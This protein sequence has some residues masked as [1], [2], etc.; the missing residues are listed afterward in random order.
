MKDV[1]NVEALG[2]SRRYD[3]GER[4][5]KHDGRTAAPA[6]EFDR[7]KPRKW[8]GKCPNNVTVEQRVA[9]LNEAVAGSSGDRSLAGPKTVYAVHDGA[10]YEAQTSDGGASYH[11]YPYRG[12]LPGRIVRVLR[13]RADQKECRDAFDRWVKEHIEVRGSDQ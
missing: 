7:K 12:P 10:V 6:I 1:K 8:I 2:T 3:K 4:R 11:G 9:L 13:Q 5:H